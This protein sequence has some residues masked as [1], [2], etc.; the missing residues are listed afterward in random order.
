MLSTVAP[1]LLALRA[2][3]FTELLWIALLLGVAGSSFAIGV[4]FISRW[5]P[6]D[7]QGSALGIYGLG[8][9]GQSAAVFLGPVLAGFVGFETIQCENKR[10]GVSVTQ[11]SLL[12]GMTF[13]NENY[14]RVDVDHPG[15]RE[16]T[17][18]ALIGL[19]LDKLQ[20][21]RLRFIRKACLYPS[22]LLK[23]C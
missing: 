9:A 19:S 7:Q 1:A 14:R 20:V 12:G 4:G 11:L 13:I 23:K 2:S 21:G 15:W 6:P 10:S 8:N 22:R 5:F 17:G 3:S 16:S 18:E